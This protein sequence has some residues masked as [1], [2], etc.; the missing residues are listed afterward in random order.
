MDI[1]PYES[2]YADIPQPNKR[3]RW[4]VFGLLGIFLAAVFTP[5]MLHAKR[6]GTSS[7]TWTTSSSTVSSEPS[8][9]RCDYSTKEEV[10]ETPTE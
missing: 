5:M 4:I 2:S 7:S 1:N 6:S 9:H 8:G 3:A 10:V